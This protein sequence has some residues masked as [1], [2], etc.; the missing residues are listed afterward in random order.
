MRNEEGICGGN[1][2]DDAESGRQQS[3]G[4]PGSE[5]HG[6]AP[7]PPV[8]TLTT[9]T[10]T[11]DTSRWLADVRK[12]C[13][14]KYTA[15]T[16]DQSDLLRELNA[17]VTQAGEVDPKADWRWEDTLAAPAALRPGKSTGHSAISAEVL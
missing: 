7:P 6:A 12:H 3:M 2:E 16:T 5:H 9:G 10:M 8:L 14:S 1:V 11:S 15:E 13:S 17:A 4:P